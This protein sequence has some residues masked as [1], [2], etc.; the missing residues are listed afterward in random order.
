MSR[1]IAL[2]ASFRDCCIGA[3]A[4]RQARKDIALRLPTWPPV[5]DHIISHQALPSVKPPGEGCCPLSLPR[6]FR[7]SR[8]AVSGSKREPRKMRLHRPTV[9]QAGPPSLVLRANPLRRTI[10]TPALVLPDPKMICNC[11]PLVDMEGEVA[12][13]IGHLRPK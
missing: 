3:N 1:R 9:A 13:S 11:G 10:S 6:R 12:D 5:L 7:L 2:R 8:A 4:A